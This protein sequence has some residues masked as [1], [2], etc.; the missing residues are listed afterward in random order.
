ML[1]RRFASRSA[2]WFCNLALVATGV[3]RS[4]V[5]PVNLT[6]NPA[7][8]YQ[9]IDG[10][11]TAL[12]GQSPTWSAQMQYLYAQDMGASMLRVPLTPD[13]LPGQVTLGPDVQSNVNLLNFNDIQQGPWGQFAQAVTAQ[14]ID[15]MK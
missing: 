3:A 6:V 7:V 15:Q 14:R 5:A 8:R 1:T 10:F 4:D 9:S 11:G 2:L 13:V 12:G